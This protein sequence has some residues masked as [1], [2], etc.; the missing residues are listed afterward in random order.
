MCQ[1]DFKLFGNRDVLSVTRV[2]VRV[3]S[4]GKGMRLE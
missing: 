1:V 2:F 3:V 4:W